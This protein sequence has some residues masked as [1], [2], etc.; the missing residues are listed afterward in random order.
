MVEKKLCKKCGKKMLK[1]FVPLDH[2]GKLIWAWAC[3]CG[4]EEIGGKEFCFTS[5]P[6]FTEHWRKANA[7]I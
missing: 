5:Y 7:N 6:Q 1:W 2:D 4:H 3:G